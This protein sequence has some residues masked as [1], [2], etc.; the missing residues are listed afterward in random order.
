MKQGSR[1]PIVVCMF[2]YRYLHHFGGK[3]NTQEAE[4]DV[5]VEVLMSKLPMTRSYINE[6]FM[7]QRNH[8]FVNIAL[9][10]GEVLQRG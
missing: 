3:K 10:Q 8:W 4:T 7:W 2:V 9:G 6:S 5:F 1:H